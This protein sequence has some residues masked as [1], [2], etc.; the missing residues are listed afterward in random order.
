MKGKEPNKSQLRDQVR[1]FAEETLGRPFDKLTD[2]QRSMAFARYYIEHIYNDLRGY[3]SDDDFDAAWVDAA[4]DLGA[5]LVHR[6]DGV[7]LILQ[8]KYA[9]RDSSCDTA[10]LS[11]FLSVLRRLHSKDFKRNRRLEEAAGEIDWDRDQFVLRYVW[12]GTLTG[13]AKTLADQP[14]AL[15][16]IAGLADR[17][18]FQVLD[19]PALKAEYGQALSMGHGAT[20]SA[21]LFP[22]G[23]RGRRADQIVRVESGDFPSYVLI[24]EA[25]QL[26][27]LYG[28]YKEALFALNIRNYLG[29]T[30]TNK[31]IVK[32]A[33][34]KPQAFF[35]LNNGIS[36]LAR[37]ATIDTSVGGLVVE[38]LQVVNGAQTVKSLFRAKDEWT[39]AQPL[40]LI[41][42]TE[43]GED[44]NLRDDIVRAN[45]TQNVIRD[46]DFRSND[47]VQRNLVDKFASY[48][49]SG[50]KVVYT[51][52]RTDKRPPNSYLIRLEE[53]SKA[54]YAY[55]RNPVDFSASTSFLFDVGENGGYRHVFGDGDHVLD[56]LSEDA[57]RLRSGIWWLSDAIGERI[58]S[59]R[60]TVTS[61]LSL[62][63]DEESNQ[64]ERTSAINSARAALERKWWV[65]FAAGL[66]LR[67]SF[68]DKAG[69]PLVKHYKGDWELGNGDAGKWFESLYERARDAV[70]MSYAQAQRLQGFNHRN[71]MRSKNTVGDLERLILKGPFQALPAAP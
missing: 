41:R 30:G 13:Q 11:H 63:T 58:K 43:I 29:D 55:L 44:R 16:T 61:W 60:D 64:E 4:S 9:G 2:K 10:A 18:D 65:L 39:K 25:R 38:G 15:P 22:Q 28:Q 45:N 36:C 49:R 1:D 26:T 68:R 6:D 53:F 69:Q 32:T 66:F 5:D 7:V 67:K 47:P 20:G 37:R 17:V 24:A 56:A 14:A 27:D 54:V 59:D 46:S 62:T 31:A 52:K 19:E 23:L 33:K 57:F 50:R 48:Y 34:T 70:V 21:T 42:V 3:I 40:L 51:P 71:W 35:H 8:V 12:L